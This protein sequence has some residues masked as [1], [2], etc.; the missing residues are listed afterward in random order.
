MANQ[1]L[2]AKVAFRALPLIA[3]LVAPAAQ[4]QTDLVAPAAQPKTNWTTFGGNMQRT[5]FNPAE[6]VLN[7]SNV[8]NLQLHWS[9]D[10]QGPS[11]TQPT[12]LT[13]VAM[14]DGQQRDLVYA[15]TLLGKFYALDSAT[16]EQ[17]WEVDLLPVVQSGCNDFPNGLVGV[18]TT[19]TIDQANQRIFVVAG[20]GTLHALNIATGSELPGWP[21]QIL[22]PA[23]AAPRT[24]AY[25]SPTL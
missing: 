14:P 5:G 13:G 8:P 10:L 4:P 25:G 2:S 12:L 3:A 6:T 11:L 1:F 23:N 15:A 9:F 19:P 21:L 22:D 24:F 20:D 18:I 16:G 17:I 7:P